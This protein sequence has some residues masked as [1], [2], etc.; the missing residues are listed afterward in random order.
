MIVLLWAAGFVMGIVDTC[1]KSLSALLVR[2]IRLPVVV[3]SSNLSPAPL[4][5]VVLGNADCGDDKLCAESEPK[6]G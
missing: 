2:R 3:F 4:F 1:T 6:V 5:V